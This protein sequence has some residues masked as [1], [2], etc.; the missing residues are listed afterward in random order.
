[1]NARN[2]LHLVVNFLLAKLQLRLPFKLV[3]VF[4]KCFAQNPALLQ[5]RLLMMI[6]TGSYDGFGEGIVV[7]V[8]DAANRRLD[9]HRG[10][11]LGIF[12]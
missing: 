5:L 8:T 7:A 11:P 1:M 3:S 4:C 2:A 10:E 9:A 12:D 6:D